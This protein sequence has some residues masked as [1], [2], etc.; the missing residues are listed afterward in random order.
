MSMT[1]GQVADRAGVNKQTLRYYEDIG[2]IEDPPRDSSNYRQ[3]P[4]DTVRRIKFVKRAQELGFTLDEI[5]TLLEMTE[6]GS[7]I[8]D[9]ILRFT[10][11]K[12][13]E[14]REKLKEYRKLEHVLSRL[15]ENCRSGAD[16][17]P[18][19]LIEVLTGEKEVEV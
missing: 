3:Y 8:D 2:L 13:E 4:E 7:E 15:V 5:E 1:T 9:E 16:V 17:E 6:G 12:L 19:P 11:Q 18:C 10:E 14:I